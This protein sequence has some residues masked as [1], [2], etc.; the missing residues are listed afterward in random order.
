[1]NKDIQ[2]L[3]ISEYLG[4]HRVEYG[5]GRWSPSSPETN[6]IIGISKNGHRCTYF[7]DE[8]SGCQCDLDYIHPRNYVGS[9]DA[10]HNV[11]KHL[12]NREGDDWGVYCDNL[13]DIIVSAA[14][15]SAAELYCHAS[16]ATRAEAFLKTIGKW[17]E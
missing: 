15:Y 1:M 2:N 11:E 5:K 17:E 13:M 6:L 9:L 4:I 3:F 8:T 16:A 10:M 7:C 14:G 12:L